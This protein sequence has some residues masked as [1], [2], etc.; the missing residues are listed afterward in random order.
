[1]RLLVVLGLL[2]LVAA[3]SCGGDD[4]TRPSSTPAPTPD[5]QGYVPIEWEEAVALFKVCQVDWALQ[6]HRRDVYMIMDD[7][8]KFRSREDRLGD[9]FDVVDALPAGCG[10]T[11][12]GT[13]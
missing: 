12:L 11:T 6:S 3:V 4:D 13:E 2:L 7:G 9:V 8:R 5:S 10:P 1:M